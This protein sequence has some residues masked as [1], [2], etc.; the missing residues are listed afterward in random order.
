MTVAAPGAGTGRLL[1]V[2]REEAGDVP[3]VELV[4]REG[5]INADL[6]L[7][8][9]PASAKALRANDGLS[10]PGVK[11]HGAGFIVTPGQ[12]AALGLGKLPGLEAHIRPYLNGRDMTGVSRGAM[13]VDLFGLREEQVRQRFP[14]VF[15]HLLMRVKPERDANNR[16]TYRKNWWIFGEPRGE[17]RP[18]LQGLS[19]YI[20]TLATSKHRLFTFLPASI[21]ADDALICIGSAEAWHLGVLSSRLHFAWALATGGVLEDRPRYNKTLCFDPFPFPAA[22]PAQ[23][24]EIGALADEIDAHRKTRQAEHPHLTLTGLYN[25]LEA[26]RAGRTLTPAERDVL[27]AGQVALL[28][29]LHERL[30]EAVAAAYG[31]PA[32]LPASAIVERLVALNRERVQE[33]AAGQVRWLRPGFQA[34]PEQRRQAEQAAMDMPTAAALPPW[35]KRAPEQYAALRA[36]LAH[37]GPARPAELASRFRGA[38]PAKVREML[39]VLASIGQTRELGGRYAS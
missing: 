25:V 26:L 4:E 12:A 6:T 24:T 23:Q 18:V 15:Q 35:P 19:R 11:L 10:S 34:P 37:G 29:H 13:V 7:G 31:W 38:K 8:A 22:T 14:A 16:D 32:D 1:T 27:D 3:R 21:L 36:Q 2:M 33:E 9:T 5:I 39:E 20:A 30:D 17:I 28:L